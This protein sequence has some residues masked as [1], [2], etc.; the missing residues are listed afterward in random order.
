MFARTYKY[1]LHFNLLLSILFTHFLF[2]KLKLPKVNVN[3]M[4][5]SILNPFHT[6]LIKEL[7]ASTIKST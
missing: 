1:R 5:T 3:F 4:R 7:I 6:D 2:I